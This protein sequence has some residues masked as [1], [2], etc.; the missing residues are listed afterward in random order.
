[1][2]VEEF[3]KLTKK[4]LRSKANVCFATAE[5]SG[6]LVRTA[7]LTEARFYMDELNR[8]AD[9]RVALRDLILEIVVILLIGAEIGIGVYEGKQQAAALN[10]MQGVLSSLQT[11][12]EATAKTLIALQSTTESMNKAIQKELSLFYD[13][14]VSTIYTPSD[15]RLVVANMGRTNVVVGGIKILDGPT[16]MVP[17]GR[18]LTPQ[19]TFNFELN[20]AH[21]VIVR[22]A[23]Q[24]EDGL[25]AFD[26]YLKN[27][28]SE[29][30]V[31]HSYFVVSLTD[32]TTITGVQE[33]TITPQHWSSKKR[34][35]P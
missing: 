24:N 32:K 11:S 13:V 2:R 10:K 16:L 25:A 1:M 6:E 9:S 15:K 8:R 33:G 18:V 23:A 26:V 27:E 17:E 14:S 21:D 5:P 34:T 29:E 12:S 20:L 19:G 7:L 35:Q 28:R 3:E 4:Q 22:L 30:F 31:I